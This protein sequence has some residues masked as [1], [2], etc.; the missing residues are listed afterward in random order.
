MACN[1]VC[2]ADKCHLTIIVKLV[3]TFRDNFL[4]EKHTAKAIWQKVK[5]WSLLVYFKMLLIVQE[6]DS[7]V[8]IFFFFFNI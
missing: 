6:I 1:W 3:L 4:G 5:S 7:G 2:C 8:L